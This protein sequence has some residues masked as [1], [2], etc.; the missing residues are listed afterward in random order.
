MHTIRY[1]FL[2]LLL[3]ACSNNNGNGDG[4][5]DGGGGDVV[6]TNTFSQTG[7]IVD[8][9]SKKGLQGIIVSGGGNSTTSDSTGAYT[10]QVPKNTAYTMTI[11]TDGDAA[12]QYLTLNEQE[13]TL[14]GNVDRGKTSAVSDLTENLLKGILQ[15]APDNTKA[16]LTVDV[17]ATGACP[18]A[19]GATVS[20]PGLPAPDA[21]ADAGSG[22]GPYLD[23]FAG[24][25]PSATAPSVT[26]GQLPSAIIWNLPTAAAFSTVTVTP[27]TGCTVVP[28]PTTDPSD[29][30]PGPNLTYSGNVKLDPSQPSAGM[31]VASFMRVFL[32]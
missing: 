1:A 27:P 11:S 9:S 14:S 6:N 19:T 17:I 12:T 10:L 26:D 31:N 18:S 15:P 32:K 24:G 29:S 30:G 25:F 7:I 28:F 3:A 4:G 23:Y 20:V 21:G 13:W 16:V 22:S 5:T 2:G 8:Y